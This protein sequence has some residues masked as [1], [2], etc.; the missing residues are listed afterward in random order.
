MLQW[1]A[2]STI[3]LDSISLFVINF[4]YN[5]I[6][7]DTWILLI[8]TLQT[9]WEAHRGHRFHLQLW[10]TSYVVREATVIS[11]LVSIPMINVALMKKKKNFE[12]WNFEFW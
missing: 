6:K 10:W 12:S 11:I 7:I 8:V 1:G 2:I 4:R 3:Y 9:I 5:R